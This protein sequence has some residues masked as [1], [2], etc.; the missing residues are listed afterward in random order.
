EF[1]EQAIRLDSRFAGGYWGLAKAQIVSGAIFHRRDLV[2]TLASAEALTREAVGLDSGDAEAR[3]W[4]G[5]VLFMSGDAKGAL[6]EIEHAL[7]MSPNLGNAH[8]SL[9]DT[10]TWSGR[11]K[12]GLSALHRYI[13]LDPR[14]P[15]LAV[16]LQQIANAHYF[17]GE[18][19][20]AAEAA[21]RVI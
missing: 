7:A 5:H 20:A 16:G 11:P 8:Q 3:A 14:S 17:C 6:L 18:Y 2:K 19:E 12:E 15:M 9:G 13:R 10:L 21:K 4:L 1:F